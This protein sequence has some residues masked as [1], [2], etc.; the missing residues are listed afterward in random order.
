MACRLNINFP[1]VP[2]MVFFFSLY[3]VG[4]KIMPSNTKH[5]CSCTD[6]GKLIS[7]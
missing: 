3:L 1:G 4:I 7:L 6:K 2:F 5:M